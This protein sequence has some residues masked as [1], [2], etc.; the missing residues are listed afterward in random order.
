MQRKSHVLQYALGGL[1]EAENRV[2]YTI[3][4]FR[5]PTTYDTLA[6]LLVGPDR[7]C[8]DE[9]TLDVVLSDLEDRGLV[10]WDKRANR[11]DLHPVVRGVAWSALDPASREG[12]YQNLASHFQALPEIDDESVKSI[13]DLAGAA[14]L[15][16]TLIQLN[17]AEDAFKIL[18]DR[19]LGV[20]MERIGTFRELAELAE[21]LAR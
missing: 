1:T 14:E 18:D 11:Y 5:A 4:A 19:I 8:A 12:I 13:D 7:P 9:A 3:A 21:M 17:R 20:M 16:H 15:Y 2:L 6:A 10:G